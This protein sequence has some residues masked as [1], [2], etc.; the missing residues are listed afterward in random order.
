MRI[1]LL[2]P[3]CVLFFCLTPVL[4]QSDVQFWNETQV[5]FPLSKKQD[6][7]GKEVERLS[8]FLIGNLR[9][10]RNNRR[11]NDERIGFG[12]TYRFNKHVTFTPSY[13]YIAQQPPGNR[14]L[15]E[16]RVR[17][18]V[19]VENRWKHV[20]LDDRN[21]IEYR[22]RNSSADGAR[23]RNRLKLAFPV[24]SEG[25]ELFAPFVADEMFYDLRAKTF[26][27]NEFSLGIG[28]KFNHH[29]AADFF[30]LWQEN[31]SGNPKRVHAFGV[32][33]KIVVD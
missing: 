2:L 29:L 7:A 14:H 12:F 26:S 5:V 15:F 23:Y 28:H 33:L 9:F 16:S 20:A 19:G 1:K 21:L 27:R 13:N 4:A 8:F 10:G 18:A 32:N 6:S 17:L 22:F 24:R 25:K 31:R 11:F 30:Y 3:L